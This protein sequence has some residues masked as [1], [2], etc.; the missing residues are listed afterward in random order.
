MDYL[1][2]TG[3]IGLDISRSNPNVLM[4][5]VETGYHPNE[6]NEKKDFENMKKL[7]SGFYRTENGGKSWK[8]VSRMNNRPFYY[9]QVRI[10]PND[11]KRIYA[12]ATQYNVSEDG[13]KTWVQKS[14]YANP[15]TIDIHVDYHAMWINP[16]DSNIYYIG[17]DGGASISFDKGKNHRFFDN[18]AVAQ[19]YAIGVDMR[20]PY[21]VYGGLQDNGSWAGVS[22]SRNS[23]GILTDHWYKVGG[24]D[25]FFTKVDPTDWTTLYVESQ[26]GSLSRMNVKTRQS[27]RIV[28]QNEVLE[29]VNVDGRNRRVNKYRYNWSAPVEMSPH[30]PRTLYF[31]ANHLF[32]SVNRGDS[33]EVISPD[34]S[35]NDPNKK[36]QFDTGGLTN[37]FTGAETNTTIVTIS[38][39]PITP[40]LIWVGTDDGNLQIT[41]NGGVNWEEIGKNITDDLPD[42]A[43]VSRVTASNFDEGTAYATFDEHRRGNFDAYVYKTTDYGQSW[44]NITNNLPDGGS[45]YVIKEDRKNKNLLFV[46]TE[47]GFYISLSGGQNWQ[48]FM[49][50]LPTVAVHDMEIHPR[51]NDIILGTH[52]R[53]IWIL[54]D[55]STLQQL[56]S[57]ALSNKATAFENRHATKWLTINKD[58][59]EGWVGSDFYRGENPKGGA[60][61]G[62]YV[63]N[64]TDVEIEISDITGN[65]TTVKKVKANQGINVYNWDLR[66]DMPKLTDNEEKLKAIAMD[67]GLDFS[68][69]GEAGTKLQESLAKRGISFNMRS[70]FRGRRG[71]GQI[72]GPIAG[73]GDYRIKLTVGGDVYNS[74]ITVREDPLTTEGK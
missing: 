54:D 20:D 3:R 25:G 39:S 50:G 29:R 69:R 63:G 21:Y 18:I 67:N 7:G 30:N 66:F 2:D 22:N 65:L 10:D 1:L 52:G 37:D 27:T 62:F 9:S 23:Y 26:G 74:K 71:G 64:A 24:G 43:W 45:T 13:G 48:R 12:I 17:N 58:Q 59:G 4:A 68:E 35:T 70:L 38:E 73:A 34:L 72:P 5:W 47:M 32:R 49:N 14:P 33:W 6:R 42:G 19:F 41:K 8:Y 15:R 53:G 11:D 40:G 31:G 44:T 16:N 56:N 36:D 55:I 60:R 28:P 61:I 57:D 46:G 51:D